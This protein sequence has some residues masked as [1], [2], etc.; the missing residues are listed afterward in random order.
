[1]FNSIS[2]NFHRI[3]LFEFIKSTKTYYKFS[4]RDLLFMNFKIY[5]ISGFIKPNIS[6]ISRM[7]NVRYF[8]ISTKFFP[9]NNMSAE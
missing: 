1:M 5:K 7:E 6:D 4:I 2:R 8:K 3:L 9:K